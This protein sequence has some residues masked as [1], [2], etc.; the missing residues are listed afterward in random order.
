MRLIKLIGIIIAALLAGILVTVLQV[1]VIIYAS[2]PSAEPSIVITDT[3]K[4]KEGDIALCKQYRQW[5]AT[6]EI[7]G[8][9]TSMDALCE[10]LGH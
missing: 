10:K 6:P 3:S 1:L 9:T 8:A 2:T 5:Q 4:L 7:K